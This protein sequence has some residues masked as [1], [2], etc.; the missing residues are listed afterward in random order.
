ML[1]YPIDAK[2]F[3]AYVLTCVLHQWDY[4][5]VTDKTDNKNRSIEDFIEE[6]S[7]AT[8]D[9]HAL[10]VPTHNTLRIARTTKSMD[11]PEPLLPYSPRMLK[12]FV[13]GPSKRRCNTLT[14]NDNMIRENRQAS[15]E[16][17]AHIIEENLFTGGQ[18][19][20]SEGD[21]MNYETPPLDWPSFEEMDLN[22]F[23]FATLP[24]VDVCI[25]N[26][27]ARS[28]EPVQAPE[29]SIDQLIES[30]FPT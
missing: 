11:A 29:L 30:C 23:D 9:T 14:E 17:T 10:G 20:L 6:I 24:D 28:T 2:C 12:S 3:N 5:G 15:D 22:I 4:I 26:D 21:S 25:T 19:R 8:A 27:Q 18:S 13:D 7:L 16:A 1:Y